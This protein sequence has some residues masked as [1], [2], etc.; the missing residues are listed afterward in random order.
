MASR[1]AEMSVNSPN[2]ILIHKQDNC[3]T[4][5]HPKY[6]REYR[7]VGQEVPPN[8]TALQLVPNLP[9]LSSPLF[10]TLFVSHLEAKIFSHCQ[11]DL[12]IWPC[13][14]YI[15]NNMYPKPAYAGQGNCPSPSHSANTNTR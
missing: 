3:Y 5:A 6:T 8:L 10:L 12:V 13:T 7:T 14:V 4:M 15:I 2:A 11:F 9:I 1:L